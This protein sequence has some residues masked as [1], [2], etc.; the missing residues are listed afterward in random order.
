M[1]E[2]LVNIGTI[3]FPFFMMK[4]MIIFVLIRLNNVCTKMYQANKL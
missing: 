1:D 4:L 3:N 2:N